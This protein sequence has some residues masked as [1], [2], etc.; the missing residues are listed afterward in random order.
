[1]SGHGGREE[2]REAA[3][4]TRHAACTRDLVAAGVSV[5]AKRKDV[6]GTTLQRFTRAARSLH[7]RYRRLG[8]P[9]SAGE[10]D[11][12]RYGHKGESPERC[13]PGKPSRKQRAEGKQHS[14]D[15][16]ARQEAK[17]VEVSDLPGRK[18]PSH[19]RHRNLPLLRVSG[20]TLP[21]TPRWAKEEAPSCCTRRATS[22][23]Q[24]FRSRRR[25]GA[26]GRTRASVCTGRRA[27]LP[28]DRRG[29]GGTA[30]SGRRRP[31]ATFAGGAVLAPAANWRTRSP[32]PHRDF[33]WRK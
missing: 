2:D 13:A 9:R 23:R 22:W 8:N 10:D 4:V 33:R 20:S 18:P 12:S 28:G 24:V 27:V 21:E 14:C 16:E 32:E 15:S 5:A 29:R 31:P 6:A 30:V 1:M 26:K 11:S 7:S 3:R 19:R 25:R 17:N